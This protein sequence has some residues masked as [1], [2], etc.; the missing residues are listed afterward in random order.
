MRLNG[1]PIADDS[2][3]VNIYVGANRRGVTDGDVIPYYGIRAD[4]RIRADLG[5]IPYTCRRMNR[6]RHRALQACQRPRYP[7]SWMRNDNNALI[8]LN[9]DLFWRDNQAGGRRQKVFF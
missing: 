7:P 2:S 8:E 9:C 1:G 6:L 5:I 4:L 3:L